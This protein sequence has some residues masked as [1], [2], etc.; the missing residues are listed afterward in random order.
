MILRR[1]DIAERTFQVNTQHLRQKML[2]QLHQLFDLAR[3][4]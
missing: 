3:A 1:L 4:P 2:A